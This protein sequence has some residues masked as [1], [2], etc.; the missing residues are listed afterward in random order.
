MKLN[1]YQLT[2][3]IHFGGNVI[4]LLIRRMMLNNPLPARPGQFDSLEF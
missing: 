3:T 2:E 4:E 1:Y